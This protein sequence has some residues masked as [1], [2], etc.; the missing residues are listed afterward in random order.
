MSVAT[1][2]RVTHERGVNPVIEAL[3]A[4][5]CRLDMSATV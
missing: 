4:D 5:T 1:T 2:F 3:V